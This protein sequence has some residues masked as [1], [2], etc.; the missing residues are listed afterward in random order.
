MDGQLLAFIV[1]AW[2]QGHML[3]GKSVKAW[4]KGHCI[5]FQW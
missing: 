2:N 5:S 1:W 4:L 3:G